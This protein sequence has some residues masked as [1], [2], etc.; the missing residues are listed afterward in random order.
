M[1]VLFRAGPVHQRRPDHRRPKPR[2]DPLALRPLALL[3]ARQVQRRRARPRPPSGGRRPRPRR[4]RQPA[5]RLRPA[6]P[7]QHAW[8]GGRA[9]PQRGAGLAARSQRGRERA[10][11]TKGQRQG[12]QQEQEEEVQGLQGQLRRSFFSKSNARKMKKLWLFLKVQNS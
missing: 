9:G 4:Q 8:R 10:R 3:L 12:D 1:F 5:H 6:Q 11:M 2:S 7:V